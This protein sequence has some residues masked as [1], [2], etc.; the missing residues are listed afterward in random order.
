MLKSGYYPTNSGYLTPTTG[1]V[2]LIICIFCIMFYISFTKLEEKKLS[3]QQTMKTVETVDL[4]LFPF[5]Y[6]CQLKKSNKN[7]VH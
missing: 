4:L 5:N 1:G 6:G 2:Y 3:K 7:Y